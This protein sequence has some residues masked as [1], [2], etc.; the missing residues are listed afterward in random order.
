MDEH[1]GVGRGAMIRILDRNGAMLHE[2]KVDNLAG[3]DLTGANLTNADLTN[4]NLTDAVLADANLTCA[5]LTGAY[6]PTSAA[7]PAGWH[8]DGG[9]LCADER[10]IA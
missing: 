3:A 7:I 9:L 10:R 4:A 1:V 8:R 6:W 5:D 2:V